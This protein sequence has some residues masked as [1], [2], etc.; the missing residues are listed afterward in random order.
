MD[1]YLPHT[2]LALYPQVF[3]VREGGGGGCCGRENRHTHWLS[4]SGSFSTDFLIKSC[5]SRFSYTFC[6]LH[7]SHII[8]ILI[9]FSIISVLWVVDPKNSWRSTKQLNALIMQIDLNI[10]CLQDS[11]QTSHSY[12]NGF[13]KGFGLLCWTSFIFLSV[14]ILHCRYPIAT[15]FLSYS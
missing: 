13:M 12:L 3:A 1:E 9:I 8:E 10:M 14:L 6:F 7:N 2:V 5:I 4:H 11:H 15:G